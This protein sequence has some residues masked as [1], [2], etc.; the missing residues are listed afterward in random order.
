MVRLLVAGVFTAFVVAGFGAAMPPIAVV[1]HPD[2]RTLQL[3]RAELRLLR[4]DRARRLSP[5]QLAFMTTGTA[6]C[7]WLP[8]R[9]TV[10]DASSIQIDMRVNGSV[11]RCGA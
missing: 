10:F 5:S 3:P 4:G 11:S 9:L 6:S 1:A 8:A 7:A 2:V